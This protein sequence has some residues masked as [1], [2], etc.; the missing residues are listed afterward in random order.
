MPL[1]GP[2]LETVHV[3]GQRQV[4]VQDLVADR[5]VVERGPDDVRDAE[6]WSLAPGI[7][8]AAA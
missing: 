2:D 5:E 3:P 7:G 8:H 6:V 1:P 4:L